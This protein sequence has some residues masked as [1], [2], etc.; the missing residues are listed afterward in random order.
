MEKSRLLAVA[1]LGAWLAMTVCMWFA[2]SGSF[3]TVN[4][5][6]EGSNPPWAEA[7]K[8]LPPEQTRVLMRYLT[9]EINRTYFRAYGWAQLVF[10]GLLF[11]IL[12]R[13]VPRNSVDLAM[14]GAMLALAAVLTFYMTPQIVE[15]GRRMDFVPRDPGPPEMSRF[16]ALHGAFT[17][18]DGAK[19]VMGLVLLGRWLLVR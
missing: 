17:G 6:L 5:V 16:R 19:L 7:A 12:L 13:R 14:A 1:I 11:V 9:S 10:G 2:A 3:S 18:T 4:R 8:P 15:L